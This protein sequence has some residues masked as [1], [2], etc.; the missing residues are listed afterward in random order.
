ML[1]TDVKSII[2]D[3][4][5]HDRVELLQ[6]LMQDVGFKISAE[7]LQTQAING[8]GVF[9]KDEE[10]SLDFLSWIDEPFVSEQD[11]D[12]KIIAQESEAYRQMHSKLLD[13]YQGQYVAIHQAKLVDHDEDEMILYYRVREKYGTK[14]ILMRRVEKEVIQ[15]MRIPSSMLRLTD[16]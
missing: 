7:M 3:L 14:P 9:I 15:T 1:K 2:A 12:S 11:E 6:Y 5:H 16:L 8:N 10:N 4:S 13:T